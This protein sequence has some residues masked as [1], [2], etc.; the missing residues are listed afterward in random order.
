MALYL[1]ATFARLPSLASPP[2]G[3]KPAATPPQALET[4][5]EGYEG[6]IEENSDRINI[7]EEHLKNVQQELVYTQTRVGGSGLALMI[8]WPSEADT[9]ACVVSPDGDDGSP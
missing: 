6:A 8:M 1:P 2:P 7:M 5:L 9:D 3:W 4:Q